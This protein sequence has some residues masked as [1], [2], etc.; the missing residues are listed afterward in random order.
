VTNSNFGEI[1]W[2]Y[3]SAASTENDRY[4]VFNYIENT[5]YIGSLARTAGVDAG[6]FRKPIWADAD[7][8]KIYEHEIGFDYG[9]LT[10]FAET[11]PIMLG[12][13]DTVASVTEMLPDERTQG[14]VNVT[15]KTRFYPNGDE[16]DYGP[17]SMSTPTSLRFTGRQLRMRVSAVELGDWR[18]GVNRIDV[19]AGGRR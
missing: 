14:D 19:V 5:W 9:T 16:R 17:Y 1:F 7:D 3:P 12:S 4:V 13:G 2:F 15:F 6:A 8:Y 10:P 18:V 11:G